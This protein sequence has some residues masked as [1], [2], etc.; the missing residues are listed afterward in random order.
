[1][2]KLQREKKKRTEKSF[3]ILIVTFCFDKLTLHIVKLLQAK[4]HLII[5]SLSNKG[6]N[7]FMSLATCEHFE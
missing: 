7:L 6:R 4:L 2:R 5:K 3:L 1:M